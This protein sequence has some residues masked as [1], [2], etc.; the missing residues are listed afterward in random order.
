MP[1][2]QLLIVVR[3]KMKSVLRTLSSRLA[4]SPPPFRLAASVTTATE[5]PGGCV[6]GAG[7]MGRVVVV[8][9]A[10]AVAVAVGVGDV[11]VLVLTQLPWLFQLSDSDGVTSRMPV[12]V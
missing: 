6:A 12:H 1:V 3:L 8:V 9:V 11:C 10:A 7:R 2:T 4:P 5:S